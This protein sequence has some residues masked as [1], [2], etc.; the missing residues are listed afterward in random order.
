MLTEFKNEA[1]VDF[2]KEENRKK[3]ESAISFWESEM[4]KS[5]PLI[6]NGEKIF[7]DDK[8]KSLNPS[9]LD[10]IV[11][12]VSKANSE[13]VGK[14]I[15]SADKAFKTWSKVSPEVRARY[16]LN[17]AQIMKKRKFEFAACMVFEV[18]KNWVEADADVAEAI[19]FLEF[20]AREMIRYGQPQPITEYSGEQNEYFY[21]PLGVGIIIP[22]WNFPL[23]ILVG[24][25]SAAIVTGNTV[26]L[27]PSSDSPVIGAKFAELMQEVGL[28]PGVLN[29]LPGSGAV[30]GD[31]LVEHPK[32]RF[33]A[34]TGS[35]EI[36]IRI[37]QL[38]AKVNPGQIWLK[39]VI[40]EMGGKDSIIVDNNVDLNDAATGVVAAA[41]GFGGQKCS[42]CSRAIIHKDVYDEFITK[43]KERVDKITVGQTKYYE[44]FMGGVSSKNAYESILNYI[45]TG[46]KE[47]RLI[48][49]GGKAEGNGW[50][51]QPTVIADIESMA[52][53]S[54]EEI[55][56]PVLA[57]LKADNFD[58]ALEIA[59]NTEYGLTGAVYSRNREHLEKARREFHVGNLYLNRKCTGALVGVH[60]FG[61]FN[62]SGTDSKAGGR[63]YL[64]L[65]LQGK[66]V[67]EKI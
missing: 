24:M 35:K 62:M 47:G 6:I 66:S 41:F 30:V 60:P 32:T 20:Y 63:E 65:F 39:R 52:R 15:E 45:E 57:I 38:A 61:G 43:V 58:H 53:I 4:G 2:S 37:N 48:N 67:A 29:F 44:N 59:N 9:N 11:G 42:A 8:I 51:I 13:L 50:F 19:D 36:G 40:A 7:T 26:L 14:A 25:T 55:F 27:K 54:Q 1:L 12:Y 56:G 5:Y 16:L 34:F 10:Q 3:M 21:I 33:I 28:P 46:K 23:A 64:M 17:A 18:G 22:P 49:G 31:T